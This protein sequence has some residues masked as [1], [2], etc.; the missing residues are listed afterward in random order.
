MKPE[1]WLEA[2]FRRC[3]PWLDAAL[4]TSP[5]RTHEREHIWEALQSGAAQIWPTP[6]SVC[7][8]EIKTFPTGLRVLFGWLAGGD[9]T[10]VKATTKAIE[11]YARKI[12]CDG[13]A[14]QG[15]RGWI[16]AFDGYEDAGMT[17][18]KRFN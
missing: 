7:L 9:L 2:E 4:Q 10:E 17:A 6:N 5:L 1:E 12:G 11:A 3:W 15:R 8:T 13:A 14:V 18:I 16:R